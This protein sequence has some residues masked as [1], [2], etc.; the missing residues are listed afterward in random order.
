MKFEVP[1]IEVVKFTADDVITTSGNG[2][3]GSE[4]PEE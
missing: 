2:E 1:V 4:S 3:W